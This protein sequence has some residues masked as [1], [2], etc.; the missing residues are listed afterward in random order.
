MT[1]DA[2]HMATEVYLGKTGRKLPFD[3][4]PFEEDKLPQTMK[5]AC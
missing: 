5:E 4:L 3:I 2:R 1:D